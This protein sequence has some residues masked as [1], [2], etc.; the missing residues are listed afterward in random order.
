MIVAG[1]IAPF[2]VRQVTNRLSVIGEQFK[3][4]KVGATNELIK[5][6][7]NDEIGGLVDSYNKMIRQ[8]EESAT[9][10]AQSERETAWREM[11]RQVAHE[12]KNPLTPMKLSIQYLIRAREKNSD[13]LDAMI[14]RVSKTLIEQIDHLSQ[15][16][17]EFSNFA[18]MPHGELKAGGCA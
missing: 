7:A 2:L 18:K 11:A 14:D 15:I 8:L 3:N 6:N 1:I 13:N 10:L 4:V 9:R 12:I 5:W 16:A 17:T